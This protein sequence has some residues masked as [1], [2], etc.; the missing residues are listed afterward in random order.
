MNINKTLKEIKNLPDEEF[1][2]FL[3]QLLGQR[4]SPN[5]QV[6]ANRDFG[7]NKLKEEFKHLSSVWSTESRI[8]TW[9]IIKLLEEV[10]K[11]RKSVGG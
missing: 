2:N 11:I 7:S 6:F 5:C 4:D 3:E 8:M 9:A 1:D 10:E